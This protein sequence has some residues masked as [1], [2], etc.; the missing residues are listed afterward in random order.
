MMQLSN[1]YY[2]FGS[3]ATPFT[4]QGPHTAG[5]SVLTGVLAG[6]TYCWAP[7]PDGCTNR[8]LCL[9]A[10]CMFW[11]AAGRK[12]AVGVD[13]QIMQVTVHP[14]NAQPFCTAQSR[15]FINCSLLHMPHPSS[16]S[17]CFRMVIRLFELGT[18]STKGP[19]SV[20]FAPPQ[21]G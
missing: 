5:H 19:Q 20:P 16:L 9:Q 3:D 12:H 7:C 15:K 8:G 6:A 4:Q 1:S 14:K 13:L 17:S 10:T 11:K 21:E 2:F 18:Q